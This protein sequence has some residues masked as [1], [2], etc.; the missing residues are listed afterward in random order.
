MLELMDKEVQHALGVT[1]TVWID[2]VFY[3]VYLPS[4]AW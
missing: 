2:L 4:L 3:T 1:R